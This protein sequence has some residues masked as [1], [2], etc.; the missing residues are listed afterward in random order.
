MK[1]MV[2]IWIKDNI[3]S[4]LYTLFEASAGMAG[5]P[6]VMP[7]ENIAD[8]GADMGMGGRSCEISCKTKCNGLRHLCCGRS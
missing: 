2:F 7:Q 8:T 3:F 1:G 5:G 6:E 4:D